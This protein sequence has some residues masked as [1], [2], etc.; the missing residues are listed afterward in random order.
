[1]AYTCVISLLYMCPY[2]FLLM[3]TC[4]C[5]CIM[6]NCRTI[7]MYICIYISMNLYMD[8][9]TIYLSIYYLSSICF[10][11]VHMPQCVCEGTRDW[12]QLS[13]LA[14]LPAEPGHQLLHRVC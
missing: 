7:Y 4:M 2:L 10:L 12:T 5:T 11:C 14:S 3:F 8:L 1:M 13:G 6:Q 9:S